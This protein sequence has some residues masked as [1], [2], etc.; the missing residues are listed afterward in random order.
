M[1][2]WYPI[3]SV[4]P[5]RDVVVWN[6]VT[7]EYRSRYTDGEFPLMFWSGQKGEWFPMPTHWRELSD[8]PSRH[9]E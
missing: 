4:P 5:D 1:T 6:S 7:G 3:A 8:G 2:K 9:A